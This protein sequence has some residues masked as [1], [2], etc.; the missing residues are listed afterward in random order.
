MATIVAC[1]PRHCKLCTLLGL[2]IIKC[3]DMT[4]TALYQ[5][6]ASEEATI[7]VYNGAETVLRFTNPQAELSALLTGSGVFDLGWHSKI[8][9]TGKDRVRWL[10]GM[11][12][13][14]IRDLAVNHGNYSFA[15]SHQ[16]RI[17]AD[18]YAYNF[19]QH[20]LLDTDRSQTETILKTIGRYIIMDDV[21][22]N[23]VNETLSA[24][25]VCG[26][27]AKNT[28]STA[29]L[30]VSQLEP[31][32]FCSDKLNGLDVTIVRGPEQKPD[33]YEIWTHPDN[34]QAIWDTLT[35]SGAEPI[36][37]EALEFWR[38]LRGIPQYGVDIRER[39]LPLQI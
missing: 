12:T 4:Q 9:V 35:R 31:L 3:S 7:G 8:S 2:A 11:I 13:N 24:I 23:D 16:G 29:G 5:R 18:L 20:L 10:N 19:G 1:L 28:L 17:L 38:V 33:W 39:D 25:G 27:S 32:Q 30:D 36:G 14:N 21:K 37:A 15:L 22:L 26:P 34:T 6:L